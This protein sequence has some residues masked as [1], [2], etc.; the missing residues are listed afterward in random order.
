MG[1]SGKVQSFIQSLAFHD[2]CHYRITWSLLFLYFS[3]LSSVSQSQVHYRVWSKASKKYRWQSQACE[4]SDQDLSSISRHTSWNPQSKRREPSLMLSCGPLYVPHS[5]NTLTYTYSHS[6]IHSY[7][8]IHIHTYTDAH[9]HT[10]THFH[11][12]VRLSSNH[13]FLLCHITSS[14]QSIFYNV[15]SMPSV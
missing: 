10:H 11:G 13:L 6:H 15:F 12:V 7:V 3:H 5:T 1:K 4:V 14:Y 8:H 2:I 9:T